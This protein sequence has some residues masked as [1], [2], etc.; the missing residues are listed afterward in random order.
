MIT[1]NEYNP[2]VG[3]SHTLVVVLNH[4]FIVALSLKTKTAVTGHNN[5][6][7]THLILHANLVHQLIEIT[8][9][10][11]A[12]NQAFRIGKVINLIFHSSTNIAIITLVA[13]SG[14]TTFV[15]I[16]CPYYL[17]RF[18]DVRF[19]RLQHLENFGSLAV[20]PLGSDPIGIILIISLS[21]LYLIPVF[22]LRIIL[23]T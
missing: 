16:K 14:H 17:V 18:V 22:C 11:A 3:F 10:I 9:N 12:N 8:V 13:K 6:R 19:F 7:I 1:P 4:V 20:I 21:L 2:V 5:D 15:F 23:I